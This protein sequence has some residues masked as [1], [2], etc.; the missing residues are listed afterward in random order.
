MYRL[1]SEYFKTKISGKEG[2]FD[3]IIGQDVRLFMDPFLVDKNGRY[4]PEFRKS[5]IEVISFFNNVFQDTAKL[6]MRSGKTI[7]PLLRSLTFP[8]VQELYLGYSKPGNRGAGSSKGYA[9]LLLSATFELI[10]SGITSISRFEELELFKEGFGADRIGDMMANLL[11]PSLVIY[12]NRICKKL[13]IKLSRYRLKHMYHSKGRVW[14]DSRV[15][16]PCIKNEFGENNFVILVPKCFLRHLPTIDIKNFWDYCYSHENDVIR[17]Q[18]GNDIKKNVD[19]ETMFRAARKSAKLRTSYLKSLRNKIAEPYNIE[20]DPE[21]FHKWLHI[22]KV[23]SKENP[24]RFNLVSNNRDFIKIVDQIIGRFKHFIEEKKGWRVLRDDSTDKGKKEEVVQRLFDGITSAYCEA[25]NIDYS[26]EENS[27]SGP[28]DFKFSNGFER[29][30]LIEVKL[31][32]NS[33]LFYGA[34]KQLPTYL[35]SH[36]IKH[37]FYIIIIYEAEDFEKINVIRKELPKIEKKLSLKI[38]LITVDAQK[39][40]SA[41]K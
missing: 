34:R 29:R 18:F 1:F 4:F 3:P 11:K 31:A 35:K 12:T 37:G 25:N 33:R 38:E 13:G 21:L 14:Q 16:L 7:E 30:T 17:N 23:V 28:V 8:E 15:Y 41:S 9:K 5:H 20:K 10:D 40:K 6:V 22:G 2:W 24:L 19:R 26:P 27:G 39:Q 36:K 32:R